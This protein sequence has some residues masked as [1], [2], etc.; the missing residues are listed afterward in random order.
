MYTYHSV[1]LTLCTKADQ[2]PTR[3][4]KTLQKFCNSALHFISGMKASLRI[5]HEYFNK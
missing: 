2:M 1:T 4:K 3:Q 5:Y